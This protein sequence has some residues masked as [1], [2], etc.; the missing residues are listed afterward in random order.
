[1]SSMSFHELYAYEVAKIYSENS[2]K[3]HVQ[4]IENR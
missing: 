3:F 4:E 2:G 1:M